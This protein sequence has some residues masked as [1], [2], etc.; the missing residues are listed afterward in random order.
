[1]SYEVDPLI[2]AILGAVGA[3]GPFAARMS[4]VID[5]CERQKPHRDWPLMRELDFGADEAAL[6]TWLPRA[7]KAVDSS[8][9]FQGLWFGLN[10]PA[11]RGKV[12]C[13]RCA[14][15]PADSTVVMR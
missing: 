11:R 8:D 2:A 7:F 15:P 14:A 13:A 1:M 3:D 5:E 4:R 12:H 9:A 10:N 6:D